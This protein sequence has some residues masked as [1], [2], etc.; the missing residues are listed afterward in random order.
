MVNESIIITV[1]TAIIGPILVLYVAKRLKDGKPKSREYIDTAFKMYE[2]IIKQKDA[3]NKQLREDKV[4]LT[5]ENRELI[6]ENSRLK[7]GT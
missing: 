5:K 7:G 1:L 4:E 6:I 2:E 3:E